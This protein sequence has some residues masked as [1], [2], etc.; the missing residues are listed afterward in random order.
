[1]AKNFKYSG[2]RVV[3]TSITAAVAAGTL[4]RQTGFIGIPLNDAASGASPIC[5]DEDV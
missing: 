1:M 3:L 2:K 4:I 5:Q